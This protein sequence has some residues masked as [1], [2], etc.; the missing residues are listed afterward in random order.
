MNCYS[1]KKKKA[2][3]VFSHISLCPSC[4]E[5]VLEAR[6][7]REIKW[8]KGE[9]RLFLMK[10]TAVSKFILRKL[11]ENPKIVIVRKNPT[12]IVLGVTLDDEIASFF[13]GTEQKDAAVVMPFRNITLKELEAYA[14]FHSVGMK[15]KKPEGLEKEFIDFFNVLEERRPSTKFSVLKSIDKIREILGRE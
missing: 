14:T 8:L 10:R 1:C 2:A 9:E 7:K 15:R 5:N 4:F 13:S 12:K 3:F 11:V 6:M